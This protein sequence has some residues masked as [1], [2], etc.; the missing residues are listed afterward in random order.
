MSIRGRYAVHVKSVHSVHSHNNDEKYKKDLQVFMQAKGIN[1]EVTVESI[2][3]ELVCK[4]EDEERAEAKGKKSNRRG[5]DRCEKHSSI[6]KA[7]VISDHHAGILQEQLAERYCISQSL[8]SKWL[9][10]KDEILKEASD[11]TRNNLTKMRRG[12]KY[13]ELYSALLN[14][15]KEARRKGYV[16]HFNW[17][18][19]LVK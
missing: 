16:V 9:N 18:W 15:L 19:M 11:K 4:V 10:K 3:E 2:V 12:M 7:K 17:L 14:E 5:R 8:V 1:I 13:L 6:F